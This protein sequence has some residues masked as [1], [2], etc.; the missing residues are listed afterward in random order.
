MRQ[1]QRVSS[2]DQS[3]NLLGSRFAKGRLRERRTMALHI[4]M[5]RSDDATL[6]VGARIVQVTAG[7]HDEL[8]AGVISSVL[9]CGAAE[10]GAAAA[11]LPLRLLSSSGQAVTAA[12]FGSL[13]LRDRYTVERVGGPAK[14]KRSDDDEEAEVEEVEVAKAAAAPAPV[15][16]AAAVSAPVA[17]AAVPSRTA[18]SDGQYSLMLRCTDTNLF[19]GS[20]LL[21]IAASSYDQLEAGV[22]QNVLGF[23]TRPLRLLDAEG[24]AV[25]AASFGSL[26]ARGR[27][28]VELGEV[29]TSC[30][31]SA[32][33]VPQRAAP[34]AEAAAAAPALAA[35]PAA[36]A[37][38]PAAATGDATKPRVRGGDRVDG[39][40]YACGQLGHRKR[41][42]PGTEAPHSS[43]EVRAEG[44]RGRGRAL[45]L[46]SWQTH[47]STATAPSKEAEGTFEDAAEPNGSENASESGGGGGKGFLSQRRFNPKNVNMVPLGKRGDAA[48]EAAKTEAICVAAAAVAAAAAKAEAQAAARSRVGAAGPPTYSLMLRSTDAAL[49]VGARIV[50][51]AAASHAEL[52]AGVHKKL[53]AAGETGQ[54]SAA[55]PA[56][57]IRLLAADGSE[58]TEAGFGALKLRDRYTVERVAATE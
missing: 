51:V 22:R 20:K 25:S 9:G 50:Q 13:K 10:T 7:N 8:L 31:S 3:A 19:V 56:F 27:Y 11:P 6:L 49:F 1:G 44:G 4:L 15:A 26:P 35:A 38:A 58:V 40:C 47:P 55:T 36:P 5:L 34:P 12:G 14:R 33:S 53:L 54:A 45:T 2:S 43:E 46:P 48:A 21:Q 37:A 28:T 16:V 32:S 29:S 17:A 23:S 57:Q 24:S 39:T 42:C 18:C 52:L 30:S 41:D